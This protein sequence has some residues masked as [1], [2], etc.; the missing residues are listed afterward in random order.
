MREWRN[1]QTRTFEGRVVYTVRVQVPFLAPEKSRWIF[2]R[3]FSASR[4]R[5]HLDLSPSR[6]LVQRFKVPYFT[7]RWIFPSA[8]FWCERT[9]L[10][11]SVAKPQACA[12]VLSPVLHDQMD[13]SNGS[14][15]LWEVVSLGSVA[16]PQACARTLSRQFSSPHRDSFFA[17]KFINFRVFAPLSKSHLTS[18]FEHAILTLQFYFWRKFG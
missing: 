10:L 3:L 18:F 7:I 8:L 6:R 12:K 15:L 5:S 11:E 4:G 1:W 13:F 14:F 17:L 9:V 16:K 2:H